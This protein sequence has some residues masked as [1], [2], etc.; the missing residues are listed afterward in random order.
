MI[1]GSPEQDAVLH[2]ALSV[3]LSVNLNTLAAAHFGDRTDG[4][5]MLAQAR[6]GQLQ[7]AL[8]ALLGNTTQPTHE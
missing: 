5:A 2:T 1:T 3:G 4:Q 8:D 7:S 6:L